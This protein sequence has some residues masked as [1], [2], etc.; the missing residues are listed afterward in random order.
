MYIQHSVSLGPLEDGELKALSNNPL[1]VNE[2]HLYEPRQE[3]QVV[4]SL[5]RKRCVR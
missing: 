1:K 2:M 5:F 3:V 4:D